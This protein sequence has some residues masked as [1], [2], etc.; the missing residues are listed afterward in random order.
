MD[1]SGHAV[2][3]GVVVSRTHVLTCAH[4]VNLALGRDLR[5]ATRPTGPVPVRFAALP[6]VTAEAT[7]R[8]WMPPPPREG[9]AGDDVCV[10]SLH[11]PATVIPAKLIST[12]PR[13]GHP[14]DVFGFPANR[15]D[16]AWVRAVV[17]GQVS[18][19]LLQLDSE[20]ALRVQPG[21]SGGPVWDPETGRVVGIIATA[22]AQDSYAIPAER[23]RSM[24]PERAARRGDRITVLHVAATRFGS[25]DR[26]FGPLHESLADARPDLVVFSGDLTGSGKPSEFERGFR[27]LAHLAEAVELPRERVVVVPGS[28]DVN[29]LA[30][31]A[32][33]AQEEALE[34]PPV[35][36]YWP[37]WGPF[38]AAFDEFY[39]GRVTFTPDEPWTLFEVPDLSVVVA[40]LNSTFEDSHVGTKVE[41]GERQTSRFV[42][43]LRDYRRRGW[44]RLGVVHRW[45]DSRELA[46][47]DRLSLCLTGDGDARRLPGG[48][49]LVPVADGSYQLISLRPMHF[50]R[51]VR[52]Y[53]DGWVDAGA[54]ET[55]TEWDSV[56][57]AF[58]LVDSPVVTGR[59][60]SLR[61]TFFER[62]H[63]ATMVSHPT[64]TVTPRADESYLRVSKPRE[65]GG[66]EQWPVGVAGGPVLAEDVDKFIVN[67]HSS[68]AAA[69]PSVPSEL[70]YSGPPAAP[71]VVLAA[72]RRGVR[73]RSF[74]EYQGLLDLRPLAQRQAQRLATNQVYPAELYVPQ[75]FA[76][77]GASEVKDDVLSQVI[78][79]LGQEAARFVMVLGDF[80]RGKSFLLRQLTR[81]LPEHLPGLLPV[82]V[83]LR[84]LEK[85]PTLDELLAQHLVREGVEAVDV[86]KL[87]YMISSGRLALLFDGFDELELRVGYDNAADYLGTL[88]H[89]VTDRAK[90]VLTSRTQHFRS[91]NQVLTALGHQVSALTASR[92]VVLEDFTDEQILD[93]LARHHHGD[94]ERA[95]RRFALLGEI[96]D[97]LGLSRNPRMLS[98]IADLDEDR[99]LEIR[100]EHGRISAAELY[101]E[102]VDFWLVHETERQQH[103]YGTPSFDD[104]ERLAACTAL[105]LRLWETTSPTIRT[106]DL[107]EAVVTRLN[108][109][110]ERGY[111][112][113]QAAHAVGSGTLLVRTEDGGFA[114]VH[115]SVM[116]WLVARVAADDLLADRLDTAIT[117]R[118]MS[119]LMVDF[120]CDLAG[121]EAVLRWAR[122]VLADV[123]A[124]DVAKQNATAVVQR[125]EAPR[126][127]LELAGIDLRAN[128]LT[129]LD[130]RGANL[131]GADLS[132]QHLMRKDLTG[133]DLTNAKL[134]GVR[135]FGGDLTDAVLTGSTW[136]RAALLGVTGAD[137]PELAEAAVSGRD[138]ATAMVAPLGED[139]SAVAF[140]PDGE[141]IA[142]ARAHG[143]E[144][145]ERKTHKPV[146]CWRR[147]AHPVE[148]IAYSPNGK[149]LATVESD[150]HAFIWDATT[151][152][153]RAEIAGRVQGRVAFLADRVH[154]V[155]LGVDGDLRYWMVRNGAHRDAVAG[156]FQRLA[157]APSGVWMATSALGGVVQVWAL[158]GHETHRMTVESEAHWITLFD[159]GTVVVGT[160]DGIVEV[161][162][163]ASGMPAVRWPTEQGSIDDLA[164]SPDG[165]LLATTGSGSEVKVWDATTGAEVTM[166]TTRLGA[167]A[168]TFS[169]D[170]KR[171]AVVVEDG[172]AFLH[173]VATGS[174]VGVLST[175]W[176]GV[177]SVSFTSDG[178]S[179]VTACED[180]IRVWD[181]RTGT[182]TVRARITGRDVRQVKVS[183][184]GTRAVT[185]T[186]SG[187]ATIWPLDGNHEGIRLD[188]HRVQAVAFSPDSR[189]IATWSEHHSL[190]TWN[191]HDGSLLDYVPGDGMKLAYALAYSPDG[192]RIVSGHMDGT[193]RIWTGRHVEVLTGHEMEVGTVACSPDGR[194]VATG[195]ADGTVKLWTVRGR[196]LTTIAVRR[197][198]WSLAFSPD[199]TRVAAASS[200]GFARVWSVQG[201]L[202]LTLTGHTTL[203]RD[204]AFSP[205]GRHIATSA[206]DGTA[207][208][209]DASTGEELVTLVHS[210]DGEFVLLP[211]GAYKVDGKVGDSVW[212]AIK[213]CR[214]EAS[215]L[216]FM[217]DVVRLP[218]DAPIL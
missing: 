198:A 108:R 204:V 28:R 192:K 200:D 212:W 32:Y 66:F 87:R 29:R 216:D 107:A 146:R 193:A 60:T 125:L 53:E 149:L 126:V 46:D 102:L 207:R 114:F 106:T 122:T 55:P 18:G 61:G 96:S 89:A 173:D 217:P 179:L 160:T 194:R 116:E 167:S 127:R 82:L 177:G 21:Y 176:R 71:D 33:F 201:D 143:V 47:R 13:S 56:Q 165:T 100:R 75:R 77:V 111:S 153:L 123:D 95:E 65:G 150:G 26:W 44:L 184:D 121:H 25:D 2:G 50:V 73:L 183:P 181:V 175:E 190:R 205:D 155:G 43:L 58:T 19:R 74:I 76:L 79:W 4:V 27:F 49:P 80:G 85:A 35:L 147:H 22:A 208:L 109:L 93:F 110:A 20:S 54:E 14:V 154:L 128:D 137:H 83:E 120:F 64:A 158:D 144:L 188:G 62:V 97:L 139:V 17:R 142:L 218:V 168:T 159:S 84:S 135:M 105:A 98:F 86:A 88:L 48:V 141:L 59:A 164:F 101:R 187:D 42:A 38:A 189:R 112:I 30:C 34:R 133:A 7:V 196:L 203:V 119:K 148:E 206:E 70:V 215:G 57:A 210:D 124:D 11:V 16:G 15:P 37:K 9:V 45:P 8:S 131:R 40:G 115:Q 41:L 36:P 209:W 132:G 69:D 72:Q 103:R 138:P 52:R 174:R 213:L 166:L 161:V 90:V 163:T 63:E 39:D 152:D 99:L 10:L 134:T 5:T 129:T 68:F 156:P 140:S 157:V 136:H 202:L 12:P 31:Q 191:S 197:S 180:L 6:D 169:P 130:L 92:G 214:F 186:S 3:A 67:V 91:T 170:G 23:L 104:T 117:N 162:D 145:L 211:G 78:D 113:D 171:I 182:A 24:W 81:K 151:G 118:K 172:S 1:G 185:T 94:A 199:G 178:S 195:S 51:E